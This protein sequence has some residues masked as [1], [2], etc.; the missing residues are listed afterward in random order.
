MKPFIIDANC[1]ESR[2]SDVSQ[3]D[4]DSLTQEFYSNKIML[5]QLYALRLID[6]S[7]FHYWLEYNT[8]CYYKYKKER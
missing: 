8:S 5:R 1:I 7:D 2:Y 3:H 4:R 6:E